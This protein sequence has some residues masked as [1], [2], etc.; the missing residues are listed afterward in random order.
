M[1]A[2]TDPLWSKLDH[3]Y[4]LGDI[5][6]TV[7]ELV[8]DWDEDVAAELFWGS[9]CHQST[10]YGA[11]YAAIP[12]LLAIAE[13]DDAGPQR[14]EIAI[15][16][17]AVALNA[18]QPCWGDDDHVSAEIM[19]GTALSGLPGTVEAW[20]RKLDGY[21]R[22]LA[23]CEAEI[24]LSDG[25]RDLELPRYR[26]YL[27]QP[28]VDQRD[29]AKI[30]TIREEFFGSLPAIRALSVQALGECTDADTAR[31]LLSG[32]AACDGLIDVATLLFLGAEGGLTC[33]ACQCSYEYA[34]FGDQLAVYADDTD[35]TEDRG[36]RDFQEGAP[37]RADG[38]VT[39]VE[40]ADQCRDPQT[41]ALYVLAEE[42]AAE[43]LPLLQALLGEFVCLGCGTRGPLGA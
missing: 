43:A 37:L 19:A 23:H 15:F 28:S 1:L 42:A 12:H 17:G 13:P 32:V 24:S 16:L 7:A 8:A 22:L 33:R 11:T 30:T 31:C 6:E 3:A 38:I 27:A 29:L 14:K 18:Q 4:G 41:R 20:D 2:L 25:L 39:P 40:S 10:L 9:L 35:A 26:R 36:L 5:N 34:L 21:R